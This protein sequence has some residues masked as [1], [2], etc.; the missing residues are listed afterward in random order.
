MVDDP[1]LKNSQEALNEDSPHTADY[2]FILLTTAECFEAATLYGVVTGCS[3]GAA[4]IVM[5][6]TDHA[7]TF[8]IYGLTAWQNAFWTYSNFRKLW[9]HFS[10]PIKESVVKWIKKFFY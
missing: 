5:E 8:L 7:L 4:A 10:L 9:Q 2:K 1:T 3:M 6:A